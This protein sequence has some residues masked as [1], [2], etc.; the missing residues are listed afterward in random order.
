M[1]NR[2]HAAAGGSRHRQRCVRMYVGCLVTA[3]MTSTATAD[4]STG[5]GAV[6]AGCGGGLL[7]Q[8]EMRRDAAAMEK[9]DEA[10]PRRRLS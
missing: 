2:A 1:R 6:Q 7:Q 9:N 3:K 8:D 5:Q 10:R 4:T